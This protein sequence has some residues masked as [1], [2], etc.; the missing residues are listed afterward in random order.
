[1]RAALIAALALAGAGCLAGLDE[2]PLT[3]G[4]DMARPADLALPLVMDGG[5]LPCDDFAQDAVGPLA[6]GW[7]EIAG[8]W[9]VVQEGSGHGLQ[10]LGMPGGL[11]I[12]AEGGGGWHNL[13]VTATVD[14]A[15]GTTDCV[16]A[17]L[18]DPGNYYAL[19]LKQLSTWVLVEKVDTL[20]YDAD[21]GTRDGSAMTAQLELSLVDTTLTA[22]IDGKVV[23]TVT[24]GRLDHGLAGVGS[25]GVSVFT[26]V[27]VNLK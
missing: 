13:D 17:R 7:R 10:Q 24:D 3:R 15:G 16:M 11:S 8:K 5:I 6:A 22:S 19:C 20:E 18:T 12:A 9:Q 23:S 2:G 14:N 25:R 27:C 26:R 21:S 4:S 1:M